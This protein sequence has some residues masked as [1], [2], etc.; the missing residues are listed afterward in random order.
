MSIHYSLNLESYK[1]INH[2]YLIFVSMNVNE[3]YKFINHICF[4]FVS[5]NVNVF[6]I[7]KVDDRSLTFTLSIFVS[8]HIQYIYNSY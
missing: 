3:S 1:F 6:L 2:I 7:D 5:M 8:R 4:I